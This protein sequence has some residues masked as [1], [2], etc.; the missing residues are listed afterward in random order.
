ML[1]GNRCCGGNRVEYGRQDVVR[2]ERFAFC[3]CVC[4]HT[5]VHSGQAGVSEKMALGQTLRK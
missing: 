2:M 5:Y 1:D 3:V 4:V